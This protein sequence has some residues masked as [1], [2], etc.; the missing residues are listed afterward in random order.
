PRPQGRLQDPPP[1][2]VDACAP[3]HLA[4]EL[5]AVR[6]AAILAM[7]RMAW[8]ALARAYSSVEPPGPNPPLVSIPEDAYGSGGYGVIVRGQPLVL[9]FSPFFRTDP[10]EAATT[11]RCAADAVHLRRVGQAS[12][13]T[14]S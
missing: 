4:T 10:Q 7:G 1:E 9:F 12:Q 5:S 14:G 13:S 8:R 3:R 11:L 2:I 6:P